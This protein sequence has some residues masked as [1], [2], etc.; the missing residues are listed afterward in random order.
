M[1]VG[2]WNTREPERWLDEHGDALYRFALRRT[3]DPDVAEDLVQETLL[4]AWQGLDNY[5]GGS[6]VG[7]W[8]TGILRNKVVDYLRRASRNMERNIAPADDNEIEENI[9]DAGGNWRHSPG[10]WGDDPLSTNEAD[11]FMA[12][13]DRCLEGLSHAQRSSFVLREL[14]DI[15]VKSASECLGVS[16]NHLY[17][18]LHRARLGLRRCLERHWF[19]AYAKP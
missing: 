5:R 11:A 6:S 7:T 15:G 14:D 8:L 4:A 18:L 2:P 16:V 19:E 12:A 9:F 1:G 17:V 3:G 10:Y 13:L